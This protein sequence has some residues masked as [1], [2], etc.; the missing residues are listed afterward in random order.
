MHNKISI[1]IYT[2]LVSMLVCSCNNSSKTGKHTDTVSSG[3]IQIAVDENFAPLIKQEIDVFEA[4]HETAG[5]VPIFTNEN[6]AVDL[7]MKD[8]VRMI[9][10]SR[11]LSKSQHQQLES[12]KLFASEAKMA[13]DAIALIVHKNNPDSIFTVSEIRKIMTGDITEWKDLRKGSKLGKIKLVFDN[14]ESGTVR[15][16][17]DSICGGKPIYTGSYAQGSNPKVIDYVAS[18]INSIGVIGVDWVGNDTDTTNLTFSDRVTVAAVTNEAVAL[19]TNSYK[20]YQAYMALQYY[21]LLRDIYIIITDPRLGLATGF[22]SFICSDRGQ[23]IVLR[24]GIVPATQSLRVVNVRNN[25]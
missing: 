17:V 13:T 24:A 15:Y 14:Q 12:K 7:L 8:S 25:L 22:T 20:P 3:V 21:P 10:I 16:A 6:R 18:D 23:R 19:K 1:T 2:I 4:M 11:K 5:I 9:I